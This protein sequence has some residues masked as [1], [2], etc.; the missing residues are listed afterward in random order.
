MMSSTEPIKHLVISPARNEAK[1]IEG[2]LRSVTEQT[3]MPSAWIIVD[4][5]STD[6]TPDIVARYAEKFLWIRLLK[7]SDR[8]F[9]YYGTG[10]INAFNAGLKLVG[11]NSF[12]YITKL[13]CDLLFEP[14]YFEKV[15]AEFERDSSLGVAGGD[16][17]ITANG[18]LKREGVVQHFGPGPAKTYRSIVFEQIGGLWPHPGWDTMDAVRSW[19][20]G[21]SSR[22]LPDCHLHHLRP[23]G[24]HVNTPVNYAKTFYILGGHPLF[25]IARCLYRL[26]Q[27]PAVVGSLLTLLGYAWYALVKPPKKWPDPA[28]RARMRKFQMERLRHLKV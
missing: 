8:G 7:L 17:Y 4:D 26:P 22:V 19:A 3:I 18:G 6:A 27:R 14:D 13:D 1:Y 12:D 24:A 15:F 25:L 9:Y 10:I 5:G 11:A 21:W 2:T 16:L 28:D 23:T 20:H